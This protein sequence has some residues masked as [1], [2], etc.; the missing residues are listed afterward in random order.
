MQNKVMW[1]GEKDKIDRIIIAE[2]YSMIVYDSTSDHKL[3]N[4][5]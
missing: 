3:S 4:L 1:G 5:D 2:Y